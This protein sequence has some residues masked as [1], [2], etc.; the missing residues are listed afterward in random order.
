MAGGCTYLI[1][2]KFKIADKYIKSKFASYLVLILAFFSL[3]YPR[4]L[5][6]DHIVI[7]TFFFIFVSLGCDMFGI[8]SLKSANL[9]GEISYSIYLLH[10]I[11]LY[12]CFI[13]FKLVDI[14]KIS[15]TLYVLLMPVVGF[16]FICYI[17]IH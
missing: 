4:T 13:F 12:V 11:V 7:L 6:F 2:S 5:S 1:Y 15:Q 14:G 17:F 9:L 16:I 8:F 3:V 10:G